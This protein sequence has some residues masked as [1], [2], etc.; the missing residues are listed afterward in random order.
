MPTSN[1]NVDLGNAQLLVNIIWDFRQE[2]QGDLDLDACVFSLGADGKLLGESF[3]VFYN[4]PV[5]SDGAVELFG[6][7]VVRSTDPDEVLQI[8][9]SKVDPRVMEIVLILSIHDFEQ[10]R[11]NFGQLRSCLVE[12]LDASGKTRLAGCA[13]NDQFSSEGAV[14]LG[15]FCRNGVAWHYQATGVG[16]NGGLQSLVERYL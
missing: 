15:K 7:A 11:Q 3:F 16:E 6:D 4:N 10:R 5:S 14:E 12:I 9:L 8:D 1:Q 13:L 2:D